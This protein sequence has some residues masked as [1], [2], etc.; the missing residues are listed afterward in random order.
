MTV[1]GI[2]QNKSTDNPPLPLIKAEVS[3]QPLTSKSSGPGHCGPLGTVSIPLESSWIRDQD[4]L[5]QPGTPFP[6]DQAKPGSRRHPRAESSQPHGARPPPWGVAHHGGLQ[7]R[8]GA[9]GTPRSQGYDWRA[10]CSTAPRALESPGMVGR[11]QYP[12]SLVLRVPHAAIESNPRGNCV[13]DYRPCR[14]GH[15]VSPTVR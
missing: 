13:A 7:P 14:A 11:C 9:P 5:H 10:Q 15:P 3:P 6:M 8:P 4:Y 1:Q 2:H 12:Q